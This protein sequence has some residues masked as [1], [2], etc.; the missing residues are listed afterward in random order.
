MIRQNLHTHTT[1]DDGRDTPTA[2]ALAAAGAGL[3]SLGFSC[4]SVLPY[5]NDW[6]LTFDRLGDY[7][8]AI[9]STKASLSGRLA[10]Y[11]GI[12]WDGISPQSTDGFDYVIGSLHHIAMDGAYPSI[13]YTAEET[14]S[15]LA[16]RFGGDRD[17]MAVAYFAQYDALARNPAVDIVGHFDLLSKFDE[18]DGLFDPDA[19]AYRDSAM[20][21]L[22]SL[23]RADKI[24]EVNTGAMGKGYRTVP[25]PAP[26]FLR[27]LRARH[28]RVL[29]S[30]DA[31]SADRLTW[32]FDDTAARLESLGFREKWTFDGRSFV[33]EPI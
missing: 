1:F 33:P 7:L 29:I 22:E 32:A 21:A 5:D 3:T 14:R 20:A 27:E 6:C 11:N 12:E 23:C 10:V 2:M 26:F 4:H 13:D 8:A 16:E 24:F 25:Y 15:I 31:H 28:A 30:S 18:T 19:P 17:A 9:E